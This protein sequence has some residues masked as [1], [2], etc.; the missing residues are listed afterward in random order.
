V[1]EKILKYNAGI[2]YYISRKGA[3]DVTALIDLVLNSIYN[4]FLSILYEDA[5]QSMKTD[6]SSSMTFSLK[7]RQWSYKIADFDGLRG[8]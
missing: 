6:Y 3:R 2:A 5:C 4:F 1:V 8:L 7:R